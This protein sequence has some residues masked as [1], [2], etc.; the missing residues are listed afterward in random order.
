M[1]SVK[2]RGPGLPVLVRGRRWT[3]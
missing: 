2:R 1:F 3:D